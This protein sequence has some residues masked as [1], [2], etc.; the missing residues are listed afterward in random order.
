MAKYKTTIYFLLVFVGGGLLLFQKDLQ[1]E[2][3]N[4]VFTLVALCAM[5]F[6]MYKVTTLK[7]TSN[8]Q[9]EE[10][11]DVQEDKMNEG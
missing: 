8:I 7:T 6:G 3:T 2:E 9:Q 10:E 4:I 5:M 1:G 11:E